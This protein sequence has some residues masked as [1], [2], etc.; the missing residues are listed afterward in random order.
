MGG[1]YVLRGHE[2]V[3]VASVQEWAKEFHSQNRHVAVTE[4]APG[5]T[6]STVFLGLDHGFGDGPPLLFETMIFSDYGGGDER[7]YSTWAEAELGHMEEV[8]RLKN[9]APVG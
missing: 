6:V 2:A 4:V 7:R 3:P 9:E 8:E 1:Y 5:V